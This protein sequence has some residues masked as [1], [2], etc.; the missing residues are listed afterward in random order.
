MAYPSSID[1]RRSSSQ[2]SIDRKS[3]PLFDDLES[4]D[5]SM[6]DSAMLSPTTTDRRDSFGNSTGPYFSPQSTPWED[7]FPN[8]ATI[9]P[10][11]HFNPFTEQSNNPFTR[12]ESSSFGHNASP[13][14]MVDRTANSQTPVAPAAY[15]G[16]SSEFDVTPLSD[17]TSAAPTCATLSVQGNVQPSAVFPPSAAPPQFETSPTD[18]KDWMSFA[19][20]AAMGVRHIPKRMRN[21]SPPRSYSP[22]HKRDG[23]IKKK[24][25]R[26][27]I[28]PER[29]LDNI[30]D[31]IAKCTD[32]DQ[33]KELKMQKR[34]LRNRQAALVSLITQPSHLVPS[35]HLVSFGTFISHANL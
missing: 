24:T 23:G 3:G 16:F 15:E 34:L 28:P 4:L 6:L 22:F 17:V 35:V 12:V 7:D 26:F 19:E 25:A 9:L 32:E 1:Y 5:S 29:S 18:T 14:P 21:E 30:D 33:L 20:N 10:E 31:F 13:W 8:S 27:D 11:R 2:L